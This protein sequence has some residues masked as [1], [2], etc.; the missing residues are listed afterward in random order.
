MTKKLYIKPETI[1]MEIEE[2]L[3]LL[4]TSKENPTGSTNKT[5]DDVVFQSKGHDFGY[6]TWEEGTTAVRPSGMIM[7]RDFGT[8]EPN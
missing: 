1:L 5:N 4:Q 3:A 2:S 7:L 8:N 6:N